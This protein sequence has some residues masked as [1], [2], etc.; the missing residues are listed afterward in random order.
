M[1]A[2]RLRG[3][4]SAATIC[5]ALRA[6]ELCRQNMMAWL[7]EACG[8]SESDQRLFVTAWRQVTFREADAGE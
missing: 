6:D 3:R 1:M 4:A 7:I 2:R 5:N 8:G